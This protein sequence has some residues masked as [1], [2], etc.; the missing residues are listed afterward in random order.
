MRKNFKSQSWLYPMP[1]LIVA[2]YDEQGNPNAMNAVAAMDLRLMESIISSS[3]L[4]SVI[5][6][7]KMPRKKRKY[8]TID[9]NLVWVWGTIS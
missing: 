3:S 8:I 9:M 2:A 5:T 7:T 1:V 4:S 6:I